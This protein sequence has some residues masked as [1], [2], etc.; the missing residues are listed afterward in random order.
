MDSFAPNDEYSTLN[1]FE[2]EL[3]KNSET[4]SNTSNA[5]L[6]NCCFSPC[7]IPQLQVIECGNPKCT[8]A[9]DAKFLHHACQINY[10][11]MHGLEGYECKK[12]CYN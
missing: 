1:E 9:F 8:S 11:D 10:E 2:S 5:H 3:E 7:I 12:L 6:P 4:S